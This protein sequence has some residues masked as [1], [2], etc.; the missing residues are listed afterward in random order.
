M[1]KKTTMTDVEKAIYLG[2]YVSKTAAF[3]ALDDG[4]EV[5]DMGGTSPL[6]DA[7]MA[8]GGIAGFWPGMEYANNVSAKLLTAMNPW[9]INKRFAGASK[10]MRT[11]D[12]FRLAKEMQAKNPALKGLTDAQLWQKV[13][14]PKLSSQKGA[15]SRLVPFSGF[16]VNPQIANGTLAQ[17]KPWEVSGLDKVAILRGEQAYAHPFVK[18][19]AATSGINP[20]QLI[21]LNKLPTTRGKV[22]GNFGRWSRY[23][24]TPQARQAL[25]VINKQF[26]TPRL[27]HQM[28]KTF[29]PGRLGLIAGAVGLGGYL[30]S[31][32]NSNYNN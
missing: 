31:K 24:A 32:L 11:T 2:A 8:A 22:V 3:G 29:R 20:K 21:K 17:L 15:L 13:Y 28:R 4:Y 26:K 30:G 18:R 9:S 1:R 5:T 19:I 14:A 25:G 10:K 27:L 7:G 16:N 6:T 23:T 12:M